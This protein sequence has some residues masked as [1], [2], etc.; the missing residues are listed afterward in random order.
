MRR[1]VGFLLRFGVHASTMI[2]CLF[3]AFTVPMVLRRYTE[4]TAMAAMTILIAFLTALTLCDKRRTIRM[5]SISGIVLYLFSWEVEQQIGPAEGLHFHLAS[6]L[7]WTT[8][9]SMAAS[10][11]LLK[12]QPETLV[13]FLGFQRVPKNS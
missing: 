8:A 10:E 4:P 1:V 2:V 7:I 5:M 9:F 11:I 12:L 13:E 6:V 3:A